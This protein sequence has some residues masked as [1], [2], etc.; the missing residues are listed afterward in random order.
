[1]LGF[2]QAMQSLTRIYI[3]P[4]PFEEKGYGRSTAYFPA[5]G[6]LIGVIFYLAYYGLS[7]ILSHQTVA[8]VLLV[9]QFVIIGG[10]HLDGFMDTLDGLLS[11]RERERK[12]EI[13]KDSRVGAFG[14][15]GLVLLLLLKFTLLAE[16]S[17]TYW[18]AFL[19]MGVFSRWSQVYAIRIFPYLR[20]Q[21]LGRVYKDYTGLWQ[22]AV[23]TIFTVVVAWVGW[24]AKGLAVLAISWLLTHLIGRRITASIGGLT[25]DIYGFI[26]ELNEVLALFLVLLLA[27]I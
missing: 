13:M 4:V 23:A 15:I 16:I 26:S 20:K 22:L 1:M 17:P 10:M 9:G 2:I 19:F 8:A 5:V 3:Y 25:G 27:K 18:F 14:V 7:Q 6:L 12:L 21:G 11:G 24:Q